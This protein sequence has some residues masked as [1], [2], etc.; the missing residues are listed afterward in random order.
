[1][2][3]TPSTWQTSSVGLKRAGDPNALDR[4]AGLE[5][6]LTAPNGSWPMLTVRG[7]VRKDPSTSRIV[8]TSDV[9]GLN[10]NVNFRTI[11]QSDIG[12]I[13]IPGQSVPAITETSAWEKIKL[14]YASQFDVTLSRVTPA[15]LIETAATSLRL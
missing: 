13:S 12:R 7:G 8:P 5:F 3:L 10:F 14:A 2:A 9:Q 15:M 1:M 4:V 11:S 6:G